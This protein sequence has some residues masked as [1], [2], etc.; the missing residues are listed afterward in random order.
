M[1]PGQQVTSRSSVVVF[2]IDH[3][4]CDDLLRPVSLACLKPGWIGLSFGWKARSCSVLAWRSANRAELARISRWCSKQP[5]ADWRQCRQTC[6]SCHVAGR[7]QSF[8]M[9][10]R[11]AV[12][13]PVRRRHF[14]PSDGSLSRWTPGAPL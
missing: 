2:F 14:V 13:T 12:G 7:R 9:D 11:C 3:D 6:P 1:I 8:R 5:V 10:A 4:S